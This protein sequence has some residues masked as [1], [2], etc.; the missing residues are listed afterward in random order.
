MG[1][2][3]LTLNKV[4]AAIPVH[5]SKFYATDMFYIKTSVLKYMA[6]GLAQSMNE[7][8]ESDSS[9]EESETSRFQYK[10]KKDLR[11]WKGPWPL[12][13]FPPGLLPYVFANVLPLT[14]KDK[15]VIATFCH[16]MTL[17][18]QEEQTYED[19][20]GTEGLLSAGSGTGRNSC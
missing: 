16:K 4:L 3:E 13:D 12:I 6:A 14:K 8:E 9:D 5:F 10:V 18:A 1:C 11:S 20:F 15:C 17:R 2:K 7:A 19:T